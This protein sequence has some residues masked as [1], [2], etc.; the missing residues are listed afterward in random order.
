MHISWDICNIYSLSYTQIKVCI[1]NF[2]CDKKVTIAK[3][4]HNFSQ[5]ANRMP[6]KVWGDSKICIWFIQ[7]L[8]AISHLWQVLM[9]TSVTQNLDINSARC[10]FFSLRWDVGLLAPF[11]RWGAVHKW[12]HHSRGGGLDTPKIDDVIYVQPLMGKRN[13][14]CQLALFW[15][16]CAVLNWFL[17]HKWI[18]G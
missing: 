8:V 3:P 10:S 11:L 7:I 1:E 14:D 4:H 15:H 5:W 18:P 9:L 12:R 17:F 13:H 16:F 6:L 2:A